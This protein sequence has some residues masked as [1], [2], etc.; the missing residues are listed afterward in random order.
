M[1]DEYSCNFYE[2]IDN[3]EQFLIENK[4]HV[5]D[6]VDLCKILSQYEQRET[7]VLVKGRL[8][9]SVSF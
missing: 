7:E 4:Q 1:K 8:K 5:V 6:K 2:N 3:E 9:K